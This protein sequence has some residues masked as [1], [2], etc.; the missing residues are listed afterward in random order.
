MTTNWVTYK[1]LLSHILEA[2]SLKLRCCQAPSFLPGALGEETSLTSCSFLWFPSSS[3][4]GRITVAS[5]FP[6][7]SLSHHLRRTPIIGLVPTPLQSG[8]A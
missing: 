5:A 6:G 8:L 3:A 1:N 2:S 4:C 7:M